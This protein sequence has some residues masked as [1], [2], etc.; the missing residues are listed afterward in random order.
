MY[1]KNLVRYTKNPGQC[2]IGFKMVDDDAIDITTGEP[3]FYT[4]VVGDD[5]MTRREYKNTQSAKMCYP[6]AICLDRE[7]KDL[8]QSNDGFMG[9][10]KWCMEC[11]EDG[12]E[13]N[14]EEPPLKKIKLV[15]TG[16]TCLGR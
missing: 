16:D 15:G 7:S 8:L 11:S 4:P 2:C 5:T 10:F 9:I 14:G 13:S 12:L 3:L 6:L 1:V